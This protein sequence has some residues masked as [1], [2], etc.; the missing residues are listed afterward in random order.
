MP[1]PKILFVDVETLPNIA[2][3]WGKYDQNV[4]G[5]EQQTCIATYAAKWRGQEVFAKALP[6]YKGYKAGSYDDKALV[7]DLWDLLDKADIAVAHNGK[8]FDFRVITGRFLFHGLLPPA[9]YKI[10]DTKLISS[11]VARFNSNKLDDLGKHFGFGE[12]I[13]TNFDLWLGCMRGDL[14][15]WSDMVKYNK[16]DV[17]LLEKVYD[18]FLPYIVDHPNLAI[19]REDEVCPK[20]GSK[21]LKSWGI[22]I[23]TTRSYRRFRCLDCGGWAR[24]TKSVGTVDIT[25][26]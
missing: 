20:C 24:S 8:D 4:L 12:K 13:K 2:W 14:K 5:F 26:T 6:D 1:E 22:R 17:R 21:N 10:I 11:R 15:C 16:Q 23:T 19:F 18:R 9:P 3:T 7:K 25:S